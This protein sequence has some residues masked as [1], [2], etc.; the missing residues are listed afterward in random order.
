MSNHRHLIVQPDDGTAPVIELIGRAKHSLY[1]KQFTFTE[2]AIQ[3]AVIARS[4]AGVDVRVMLNPARSSGS[5]ANDETFALFESAGVPV[6]WA[7]PHFAVTHE[8]S[9]VVDKSIALIATFNLCEKYFTQTRDYGVIVENP[10]QVS[11]VV[12]GF[13]ADWEHQ[14]WHPTEDTGLLWSNNNSR[15]LM[16]DFIDSAQETLEVQHPKFV[17]ATVTERIAAAAQRGVHVRVLCGG[18]HGISE[19][20]ILD[21]FS[22]LRLLHYLGVKVHKQK[23]LRLHAKLLIADGTHALIGSMNIDRSAF[24]LRRELGTTVRDPQII[25]G[26]KQVFEF[27]WELSHKYE[28]PEPL[29]AFH[30]VENDFPHDPDLHHE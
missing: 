13:H 30:H 11:Q 29:S 22:S 4:K 28:P 15:K 17:D 1:I 23:N 14:N 5:R 6:R 10:V 26:V 2:P 16:S 9:I 8:K 7:S 24:D 20:D 3:Q 27:D 25:E 19:W 12:E 18:K 21:T